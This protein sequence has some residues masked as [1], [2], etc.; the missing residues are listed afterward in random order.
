MEEALIGYLLADSGVT[1]LAQTG[2]GPVRLYW[3][4]AP[5][6][7]AKPYA[8]LTKVTGLRDTPMD[9]PSG[10]QESRIQVDCYGLTFSAAKGLARAIEAALSG[11]S[12]ETDGIVFQGVFLDAERDGYEADASP[13]KL[14]RTSLDFIIYHRGV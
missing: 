12:T 6:S 2:S 13:D 14:F 4:Q 10:L 3:T 11:L 8:T 1:A 5:Q 7:V 9:G